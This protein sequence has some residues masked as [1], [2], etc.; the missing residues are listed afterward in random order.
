MKFRSA[1]LAVILASLGLSSCTTTESPDSEALPLKRPM[2]ASARP[3]KHLLRWEDARIRSTQV[4]DVHYR[5]FFDLDATGAEFSGVGEIQFQLR[6]NDIPLTIDFSEGAISQITSGGLPVRYQK[7]QYFI[8]IPTGAL[9]VGPQ[10]LKIHFSRAYSNQ[11]SGLY[12]FKDP[13]DKKVYLYSNFEPYNANQLFPCFDQPDIK[14]TYTLTTE[15][16][17]D[18]SVIS[19]SR[20]K[21]A[22]AIKSTSSPRQRWE[23]PKTE[24]FSTYLFALIAGPFHQWSS[25][26]GNIPLRLFVRQSLK[27]FVN[28]EDWFPVTK[29]GFRFFQREFDFNYPF[30]KYDQIIV[31]D[32]NSGAMENVG[33]VTF[34]ERFVHRSRMTRSQKEKLAGVI[35][36]E[37]A[38]MWFGNL[39]TMT[40]WND[41]WLNESFA[42]YMAT[43]ALV[44]TTEFKTAWESYSLEDKVRAAGEDQMRTTHAIDTPVESTDVAFANFDSITYGKGGAALR[45]IDFYLGEEAFKEGVRQYFNLH[46]FQNATRQDFFRSLQEAAQLPLKEWQEDWIQ[47]SGISRLAVDWTC[48]DGTISSINLKVL[49]DPRF[50]ADR[51]HKTVVGLIQKDG[52]QLKVSRTFKVTVQNQIEVTD[53][54][55]ESCPAAVHPNI[56]DHTYARTQLDPVSLQTLKDQLSAITDPWLRGMGWV[57]LT[58]MFRD[59]EISLPDFVALVKNH[60]P[61]ENNELIA[62]AVAQFVWGTDKRGLSVESVLTSSNR[63]EEQQYLSSTRFQL[64]DLYWNLQKKQTGY[65]MKQIYTEAAIRAA[66]TGPNLSK[67]RGWLN[68]RKS[69]ELLGGQDL[70]WEILTTLTRRGFPKA[71]ALVQLETGKDKSLRGKDSAAAALAAQPLESAKKIW[72]EQA[73]TKSGVTLARLRTAVRSIF[74]SEQAVLKLAFQPQYEELVANAKGVHDPAFLRTVVTDFFPRTCSLESVALSGRLIKNH[75]D[76]PLPVMK[77]LIQIHEQEEKCEKIRARIPKDIPA[78]R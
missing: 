14:A 13:E 49:P 56:E 55:G 18:W 51:L 75:S 46:A 29:A 17:A 19:N 63:G 34:S 37:M 59:A 47:A 71:K 3:D 12:R 31:P 68:A 61:A 22:V 72:F 66:S 74:P 6:R 39:V 25:V 57:T 2:P 36:H 15:V 58:Q 62:S 27:S 65:D 8:E 5:L 73:K 30:K 11:G 9:A 35:L 7:H 10:E 16:P 77:S 38:H 70:R 43:K 40:W 20:E 28:P 21:S 24:K 78:I 33:A 45:Q 53:A 54:L 32:F 48:K 26:A 60:L 23:F 67:I 41:L 50:P 52:R 42:T 76:L 1:L 44:K 64:E 69:D 4:S